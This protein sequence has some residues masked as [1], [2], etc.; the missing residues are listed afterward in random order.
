MI[1]E[2]MTKWW[3]AKQQGA[4]AAL[5]A[6]HCSFCKKSRNKVANLVAGP[7]GL[8]ICDQCVALMSDIIAEEND[9]WRKR[10]IKSLQRRGTW[11]H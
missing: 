8:A 7:D 11:A 10:Q 5:D 2:M 1:R 3:P 9:K 6:T 4:L